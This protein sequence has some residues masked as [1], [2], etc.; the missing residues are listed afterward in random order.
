MKGTL[1]SLRQCW[2]KRHVLEFKVIEF[3]NELKAKK[4]FEVK[5]RQLGVMYKNHSFW[6]W[7]PSNGGGVFL[8]VVGRSSVTIYF[9]YHWIERRL[10]RPVAVKP[11][12]AP[13]HTCHAGMKKF[14]SFETMVIRSITI[15]LGSWD[16]KL[17]FLNNFWW[18]IPFSWEPIHFEICLQKHVIFTRSWKY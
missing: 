18:F 11:R 4:L 17:Q 7:A 8:S 15:C 16:T 14:F 12:L 6:N 3:Q 13:W 10:R 9:W 1:T 5:K 2:S